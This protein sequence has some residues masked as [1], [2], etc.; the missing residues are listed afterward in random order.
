[1]SASKMTRE[2]LL[3]YPIYDIP[4]SIR[5]SNILKSTGVKTVGDLIEY[6]ARQLQNVRGCG[7]V[8]MAEIFAILSL[9]NLKMNNC[10]GVCSEDAVGRAIAR[11]R[12]RIQ[13]ANEPPAPR[14]SKS[15]KTRADIKAEILEKRMK[16]LILRSKNLT[17][18]AIA[19]EIGVTADTARSYYHKTGRALVW[20]AKKTKKT[21]D[22]VMLI[23]NLP[24]VVIDRMRKDGIV[25]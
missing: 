12:A 5:A 21:L 18:K 24:V 8:T 4:F 13:V 23:K 14:K 11:I 15:G 2:Q 1:M 19:A 17:Y 3:A 10:E 22:E 7:N 20:E 25:F 6:D 16:T 9:M